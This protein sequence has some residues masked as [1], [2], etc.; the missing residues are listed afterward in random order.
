MRYTVCSW[1]TSA[2]VRGCDAGEGSAAL[3]Q[4]TKG[5]LYRRIRAARLSMISALRDHLRRSTEPSFIPRGHGTRGSARPGA[6]CDRRPRAL[7]LGDVLDPVEPK[8]SGTGHE[9]VEPTQRPQ[10]AVED[11]SHRGG[12]GDVTRDRLCA[13]TLGLDLAYDL[14]RRIVVPI[15]QDHGRAL[16]GEP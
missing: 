1:F 13:P 3:I 2:K 9:D 10:R 8:D 14:L 7:G 12:V 4:S 6:P 11:A 16:D 5:C 15:D